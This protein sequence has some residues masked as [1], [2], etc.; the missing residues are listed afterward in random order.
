MKTVTTATPVVHILRLTKFSH[1]FGEGIT[2]EEIGYT[3]LFGIKSAEEFKR[4]FDKYFDC[5][6]AEYYEVLVDECA[7]DA[8]DYSDVDHMQSVDDLDEDNPFLLDEDMMH[9]VWGVL[10]HRKYNTRPT[11]SESVGQMFD[12][13]NGVN[14]AWVTGCNI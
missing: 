7:E 14:L 2:R 4:I 3:Y 13:Y 12:A 11:F 9:Y 6:N 8:L 1:V 5:F 10:N